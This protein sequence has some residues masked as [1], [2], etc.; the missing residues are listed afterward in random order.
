MTRLCPLEWGFVNKIVRCLAPRTIFQLFLLD[1]PI[2]IPYSEF[3]P[4]VE[5]TNCDGSKNEKRVA[6]REGI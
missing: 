3:V 1:E 2:F 5:A 4:I 6:H